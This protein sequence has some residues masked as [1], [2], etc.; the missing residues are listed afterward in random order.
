LPAYRV[1]SAGFATAPNPVRTGKARCAGRSGRWLIVPFIAR[2]PDAALRS[3]A[4]T[5]RRLPASLSPT[6]P[7]N[8]ISP[9][10]AI[11]LFVPCLDQRQHRRKSARIVAH[12]KRHHRAGYGDDS[13]IGSKAAKMVNGRLSARLETL[14]ISTRFPVI[15]R[16]PKSVC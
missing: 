2:V 8:M 16:P 6:G 9:A 14:R 11:L 13:A 7:T 15:I 10:V 5:P 1:E 3:S 4:F 12:A